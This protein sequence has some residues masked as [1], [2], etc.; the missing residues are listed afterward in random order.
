MII[1]LNIDK[2]EIKDTPEYESFG[3]NEFPLK[4]LSEEELEELG[5]KKSCCGSRG[6]CPKKANGTCGGCSSKG[7]CQGGGSKNGCGC[8]NGSSCCKNK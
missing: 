8:S 1:L 3:E 6:G 4:Y 5:F 7:G 2:N